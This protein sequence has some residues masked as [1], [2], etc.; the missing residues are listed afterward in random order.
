MKMSA[1]LMP[2]DDRKRFCIVTGGTFPD[3]VVC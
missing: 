1:V 2:Q 3:A